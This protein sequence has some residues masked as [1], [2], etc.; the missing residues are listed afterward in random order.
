MRYHYTI[1]HVAGKNF[2]TA[3]TLSRAPLEDLDLQTQVEQFQQE[4]QAYVNLIIDQLPA[5]DDKMKEILQEQ[6][7]DTTCQKIK[8]FCQSGWPSKSD[9]ESALKPYAKV[10]SELNVA[11]GL[12]LRGNRIVIPSKLQTDSVNRLH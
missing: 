8:Y 4:T 10:Q 11:R 2:C 3:D 7:C 1:S 12:L 9:L 5:T 6:E